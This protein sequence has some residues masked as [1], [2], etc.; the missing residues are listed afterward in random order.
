MEE[1]DYQVECC[2]VASHTEA[3]NEHRQGERQLADNLS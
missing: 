2:E 1:L 3:E